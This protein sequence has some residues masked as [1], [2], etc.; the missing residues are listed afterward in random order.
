MRSC[1]PHR[2]GPPRITA[3]AG[4][5]AASSVFLKLLTTHFTFRPSANYLLCRGAGMLRYTILGL[6]RQGERIHGYALWKAYE[7]RSG[8]RIQ[9]GKFYRALK[10]LA[11]AG[12]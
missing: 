4:R 11:D 5:I 8:H 12:L 1:A 10:I 9:N 3:V 2:R 6:L 7:R